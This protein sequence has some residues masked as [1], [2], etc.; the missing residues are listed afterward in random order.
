[1]TSIRILLVDDH[2]LVRRGVRG[3]LEQEEDMEVVGDCCSAE[4]ALAQT[5]ILSPNILLMEP[6]I[7]GI[8]GI[9]ATRRL[10][11]KHAP[12]NI[13]MLSMSKDYLAEAL[14]AGAAGYLLLDIKCQDLARAIRRVYRG[15]LVI[16]ERLASTPQ[17]AED[18]LEYLP[19]EGDGSGPLVKKAELIIPPPVE[20]APLLR[21]VY[22]VEEALGATILQQVG[23]WNSGSAITILLK[24]AAPLANILD[25]L[26]KMPDVEAAQ[27]DSAARRKSLNFSKKVIG[28]AEAC[29]GGEL[30]VTLKQA[31]TAE[32]SELAGLKMSSST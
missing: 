31:S 18:E 6:K 28:K 17:V 14:E 8:G 12:C 16:D 24:R 20:A 21:F 30:L 11:Q 5:E 19:L 2:E 27:E 32:Q 3:I 13:I 15:E 1:M 25:R 22:Q 10:H 26:E 7:P 29:P 23:S 9:E 4:E